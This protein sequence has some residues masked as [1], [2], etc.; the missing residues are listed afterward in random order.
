V[1]RRCLLL[2]P[3]EERTL[4]SPLLSEGFSSSQTGAAEFGRLVANAV[5]QDS[6]HLPANQTNPLSARTGIVQTPAHSTASSSTSRAENRVSQVVAPSVGAVGVHDI[7]KEDEASKNEEPAGFS[8][9]L[10]TLFGS[11]GS[12]TQ[13][14]PL[15]DDLGVRGMASPPVAATH[16][17]LL[18]L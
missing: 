18:T 1:R 16:V 10:S 14:A 6:L 3:L 11:S 5:E 13:T 9:T 4:L 12:R 8:H 2:D 15:V 17:A 7:T